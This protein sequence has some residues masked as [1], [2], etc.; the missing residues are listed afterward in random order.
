MKTQKKKKSRQRADAVDEK[1]VHTP[2]HRQVS[3]WFNTTNFLTPKKEEEV[4]RSKGAIFNT[5]R[6]HP[7]F[8]G[9]DPTDP[10]R[11]AGYSAQDDESINEDF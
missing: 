6:D 8:H 7:E 11:F 4:F 3:K 9:V 5:P 10:L 1:V 2:T